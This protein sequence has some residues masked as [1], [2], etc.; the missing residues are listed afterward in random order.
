MPAAET[1]RIPRFPRC[2]RAAA[3]L[4]IPARSHRP[5]HGRPL[6]MGVLNVTPDSFSDGGD[7][8]DPDAATARGLQMVKEGAG[9]IDICGVSTR[10]GADVVPVD[11]ELRRVL[12][13]VKRLAAIV[14]VPLSIDTS[15]AEVAAQAL[16]AGASI[17][18]DVTALRGD[19][20]MAQVAARA[21]ATVI[22]MHMRGSPQTMQ[23]RPRYRHVV[24]EVAAFLAAAAARAQAEDIARARILLDPGLGFGKT[25]T[26]NLELLR[27]LP[28]LGAL[29]F[30]LVL[31]PS[32]KSFI[33]A[34]LRLE[35]PDR[36]AGTLACVAHAQRYGVAMIRVHDVQPAVHLLDMLGAIEQS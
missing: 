16:A 13:V 12:P 5:R 17:I 14:Q 10:P 25:A 9:V 31:G 11:E 26:H 2:E 20:R 29:G 22:L 7:F 33:G 23:R 32:R 15:S 1:L 30:P 24:E 19:P 34:I 6:V 27:G 18:N 28:R 4:T 3:A 35:A 8:L 21:R 36:L